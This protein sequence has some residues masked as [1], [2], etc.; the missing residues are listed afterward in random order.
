MQIVEISAQKGFKLYLR[1]ADGVAGVVDLAS[2]AGQGVFVTWLKP[3]H[4]EQV[5][6][7]ESGAAEW[8]GDIDLCSDALY[9]KLT[10]KTPEELFPT[11]R[12]ISTHA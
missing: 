3:G 1:Y 12:R 9:L 2:L 8:P 11:L 10:G 4:F 7:S 5:R 6:L